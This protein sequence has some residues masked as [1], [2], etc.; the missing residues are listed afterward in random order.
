MSEHLFGT[1]N[2]VQCAATQYNSGA[3]F[4][5]FLVISIRQSHTDVTRAECCQL[6]G[7]YAAPLPVIERYGLGA[8]YAE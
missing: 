4:Q 1:A 8:Q 6:A 2:G 7:L 3:R 5:L